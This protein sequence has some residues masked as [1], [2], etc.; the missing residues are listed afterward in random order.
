MH[1]V[2]GPLLVLWIIYASIKT[3]WFAYNTVIFV[4][5]FMKRD[6][7]GQFEIPTRNGKRRQNAKKEAEK[8]KNQGAGKEQA[9]KDDHYK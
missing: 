3:V 1:F 7:K 2:V 4:R 8:K 5:R 6:E 9:G